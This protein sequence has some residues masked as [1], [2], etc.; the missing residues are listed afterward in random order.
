MAMVVKR[1]PRTTIRAP[2][3]DILWPSISMDTTFQVPCNIS[4]SCPMDSLRLQQK[5]PDYISARPP[6]PLAFL[7]DLWVLC[8]KHFFFLLTSPSAPCGGEFPRC[9]RCLL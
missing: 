6:C 5:I 7:G 3:P 2:P 9:I 4:R 8:A 1:F